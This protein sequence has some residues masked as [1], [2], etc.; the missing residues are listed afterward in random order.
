MLKYITP[1]PVCMELTDQQFNRMNM[2]EHA[3]VYWMI[4]VLKY[5]LLCPMTSTATYSYTVTSSLLIN[6]LVHRSQHLS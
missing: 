6:Q 3:L 1:K 2:N 4:K 5:Y